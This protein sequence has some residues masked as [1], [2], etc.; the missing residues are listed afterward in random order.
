MQ[1]PINCTCSQEDWD[2]DNRHD[3]N[4]PCYEWK[5]K[6][7][8]DGTSADFLYNEVCIELNE[9]KNERDKL[10]Q[11]VNDLQSGLYINCVY[12]GYRFGPEKNTPSSMADVLK[13]HI[14]KCPNHPMSKLKKENEELCKKIKNNGDKN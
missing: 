4:C 1:K 3:H 12:C 6:L 2:F 13:N 8:C 11:W 10:K 7:P 5:Y 14:E 9:V